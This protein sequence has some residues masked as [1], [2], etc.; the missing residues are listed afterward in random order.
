MGGVPWDSFDVP[1]G[2]SDWSAVAIRLA[3]PARDRYELATQLDPY[4]DRGG[5]GEGRESSTA[6]VGAISCPDIGYYASADEKV[7]RF[8]RVTLSRGN[9]EAKRSAAS[10]L[11]ALGAR[12][13]GERVGEFT[14]ALLAGLKDSDSV[15]QSSAASALGALGERLPGD[16][17]G[18]V[19]IALLA[20]L[21]DSNSSVLSFAASDV[22]RSAAYAPGA[23]GGRLQGAQAELVIFQLSVVLLG[24][25]QSP[26]SYG[27][28]SERPAVINSIRRLTADRA[29][30]ATESLI[31]Y[32]EGA[33]SWKR[34]LA[35]QT[36]PRRALDPQQEKRLREL[37]D[38]RQGRPWVRMAA[39][40]TL[41]E[42]ERER[43]MKL[44]D[45]SGSENEGGGP[46][47]RRGRCAVMANTREGPPNLDQGRFRGSSV[48]AGISFQRAG[49]WGQ[50]ATIDILSP[51][52]RANRA[53]AE[54]VSAGLHE[55]PDPPGAGGLVHSRHWPHHL[56][57]PPPRLARLV[58]HAERVDLQSRS[59]LVM[60]ISS[61]A[62]T[63]S[64]SAENL[65]LASKAPTVVDVFTEVGGERE[66]SFGPPYSRRRGD[67]PG[68]ERDRSGQGSVS[69][70][71]GSPGD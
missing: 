5:M 31:Q 64:S 47:H 59:C 8:V 45:E 12:L 6:S 44:E 18:E 7:I 52:R 21:K 53:S 24:A 71:G 67:G 56:G 27:E 69:S 49:P 30:P 11:G 20:A 10:A 26:Q 39:L 40:D 29:E 17:V 62:R 22:Q 9:L 61:P 25:S 14:S 51:K 43:V 16:T 33:D 15:V 54:R 1:N 68:R 28:L 23:L 41:M 57:P 4:G 32:L 58:Q 46:A 13:P 55:P 38:D 35:V 3:K 42:I 70:V 36:L 60:V 19:T 34:I 2:L 66:W 37:R 48:F 63:R 50:T 65:V